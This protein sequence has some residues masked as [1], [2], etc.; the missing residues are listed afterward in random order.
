MKRHIVYCFLLVCAAAALSGQVAAQPVQDAQVRT[1]VID[2]G[3]GGSDAGAARSGVLEKDINLKVALLLGDMITENLPDVQVVYTRKTDVFVPLDE[4][5]NIANKVGADLFLSIHVNST[6]ASTTNA[7]GTETYIM[8]TAKN[9]ANLEVAMRENNAITYEEDYSAKYEG[10][11]PSSAESFIIFSLMQYAYAEQSMD[12]ATTVQRHFAASA[13][14]DRG[15]KQAGYLVLWRTAMPAVLTE[16]GF[17]NNDDDRRL[18]SSEAGQRKVAA[19][20][21]NAFSEYKAKVEG[22]AKPLQLGDMVAVETKSVAPVTPDGSGTASVANVPSD[23]SPTPSPTHASNIVFRVQVVAS[24]TRLNTNSPVFG[25]YRNKLTEMKIGNFY[26]YF[27]GETDTFAQA[28]ALRQDAART[29]KDAFVVAF[30]DGK[31][32]ALT[33]EMKRNP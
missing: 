20:L 28:E 26:K 3:H 33:D 24:K 1:I 11:D 2:P 25:P 5:G 27:T 14:P 18:L 4:R 13:L 31:Q 15:A 12:F 29:I 9:D 19:A 17:V 7:S 8:G 16:L 21:F 10:Y 30:R 23:A 6:R 32:V 22:N